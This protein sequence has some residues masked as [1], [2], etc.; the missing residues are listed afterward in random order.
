VANASPASYL[1]EMRYR[2]W[3]T[4]LLSLALAGPALPAEYGSS[5]MIV[6]PTYPTPLPSPQSPL[7]LPH[8]QAVT[9]HRAETPPPLFVPQ[10]GRVLPNLPATGSGPGGRE[11]FQDRA[12]RCAHQSGLYGPN[13]TGNPNTYLNSCTNQ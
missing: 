4:A 5:G 8:Q 10:T 7:P 11:T 13:A 2:L 6:N 3:L 9:P 12:N 1:N